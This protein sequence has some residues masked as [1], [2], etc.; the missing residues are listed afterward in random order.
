MPE[1]E[2]IRG[3]IPPPLLIGAVLGDADAQSLAWSRVIGALS[4]RVE[5]LSA[6]LASPVRLNLIYHVDGKIA[7][8]EFDGVRTGRFDK[9]QSLLVMQAAVPR[10]APDKPEALLVELLDAAVLA[11]E[12]WGRR[13]GIADGLPTLRTLARQVAQEDE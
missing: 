3:S 10:R 8:N 7:P 11:A 2:A 9:A 5:R 12:T 4:Q 6:G 1:Q 13:R